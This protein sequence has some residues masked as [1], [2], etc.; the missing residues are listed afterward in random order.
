MNIG[1]KF[2][3]DTFIEIGGTHKVCEDY[4]IQTVI[5]GCP[6]IVLSDG[7]SSSSNTDMGARILCHLAKQYLNRFQTLDDI[8]YEKMGL[9]VIH[10][11]E[12]IVR[13]LGLNLECLDATLIVSILNNN[14]VN[15][16]IYGDGTIL[17]KNQDQ[18]DIVSISFTKNAPYYL[19]YLID[20]YKADIYSEEGIKKHINLNGK[21]YDEEA[22]DYPSIYCK[23]LNYYDTV[24]VTSDGI[25]SFQKDFN[26]Y[27][28]NEV[29]KRF[30]DIK[31]RNGEFLKR[32]LKSS[33]KGFSKENITHYDDLSVG[34]FI[35]RVI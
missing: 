10:N 7:C 3:F 19:S 24:M 8:S 31:V 9:W 15:T 13:Q 11:A 28:I 18:I 20:D 34:A 1:E 14:T 6:V 27:D 29:A 26:S 17:F 35:R 16:F 2:A 33:M 22:Y 21:L 25:E 32:T 30:F 23:N 5:N 12:L 4:I